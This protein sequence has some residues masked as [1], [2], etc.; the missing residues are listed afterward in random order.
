MAHF[1]LYFT[2][3]FVW[4]LLALS[5]GYL[6]KGVKV[7]LERYNKKGF[8][9]ISISSVILLFIYYGD[10]YYFMYFPDVQETF[11]GGLID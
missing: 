4:G 5:L 3:L 6:F 8:L 9:Y 11:G 1:L 10:L 2:G 7:L